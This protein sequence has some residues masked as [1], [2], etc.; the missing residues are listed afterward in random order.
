MGGIARQLI[1]YIFISGFIYG[2]FEID[3]YLK[4]KHKID[5]LKAKN[6]D[7]SGT[8]VDNSFV[9]VPLIVVLTIIM[10]WCFYLRFVMAFMKRKRLVWV[11]V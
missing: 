5:D 7:S 9:I 6:I 10:I 1:I 8:T 11:E 3:H 4:K 2:V